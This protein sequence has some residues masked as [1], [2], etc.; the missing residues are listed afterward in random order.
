MANPK[1][2]GP[3]NWRKATAP[4]CPNPACW[5]AIS[6]V[7]VYPDH[8]YCNRCGRRYATPSIDAHTH[9]PVPAV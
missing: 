8:L 1:D 5:G 2:D 7:D 6:M 9:T 4:E 3:S